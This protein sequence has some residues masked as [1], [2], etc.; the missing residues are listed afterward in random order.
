MR[1]RRGMTTAAL[2]TAMALSVLACAG[3]P[4]YTAPKNPFTTKAEL[5]KISAAPVPEKVKMAKGLA[6]ETWDLTGPFPTT[7]GRDRRI[8]A[9]PTDKLVD[10]IAK[11]QS[12]VETTEQMHCVAREFGAFYLEKKEGPAEDIEAFILD[13]CGSL[14][15]GVGVFYYTWDKKDPSQT[16]DES[17]AGLEAQS[18][19][20]A[21]LAKLKSSKDL[22]FGGWFGQNDKGAIMMFTAARK[23]LSL[24]P[25][26]LHQPGAQE[27]T[28]EGEMEA[29]GY[30]FMASVT[31]KEAGYSA[32][33]TDTTVKMPRFRVVCPVDPTSADEVIEMSMASRKD[34]LM[35]SILFRKRVWNATH[36][37][38]AYKTPEALMLLQDAQVPDSMTPEQWPEVFTKLVNVLRARH[39]L[40]ALTH[41]AKQSESAST[42]TPH[43]LGAMSSSDP[44]RQREGDRIM[45]GLMAGW[46]VSGDIVDGGVRI[47]RL[48][49]ADPRVLLA[50]LV[51]SPSGR[52]TVYSK[53]GG[54]LA[55]GNFFEGDGVIST[56][57]V[58]NF[59]PK[60]THK[61]RVKRVFTRLN[62]ARKALG[63]RTIKRLSSYE[64]A[65]AAISARITKGEDD[66]YVGAGRL[67]GSVRDGLD[68]SVRYFIFEIRDLE[69][70]VVPD[71]LTA[72][73]IK[74]GAIMVAPFRHKGFPW[75]TYIVTVVYPSASVMA[76]G[77]DAIDMLGAPDLQA[78]SLGLGA[79][80]P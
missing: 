61:A 23:N 29:S 58:Y 16:V 66:P 4:K 47:Q 25:L 53:R 54:A 52:R 60:E 72:R 59:L 63:R 24:T 51:D 34:A 69:D 36:P 5:A 12:K 50:M 55:M 41:A 77:D 62:G 68:A 71:E 80:S 43:L 15:L 67:A 17:A 27:I 74:K 78:T 65:A 11:S 79:P 76:Q 31:R 30:R 48:P 40:P 28:L 46:N 21:W 13:R 44:D 32:C 37:S 75:M 3:A 10:A 56:V 19:T 33:V 38:N 45:L 57:S 73:A 9:S 49:K 42:L 18:E 8:G 14:A 20:K 6:L 64:K 7:V 70:F 1:D 22:E 2:F 35:T 39:K 26:R